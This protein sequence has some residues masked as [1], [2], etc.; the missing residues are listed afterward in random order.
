[1][2]YLDMCFL[3]LK[4]VYPFKLLSQNRVIL[5]S[6]KTLY[7]EMTE[8]EDFHI[9]ALN[10]LLLQWAKSGPHRVVV[11]SQT[12]TLKQKYTP[13]THGYG[14]QQK[15]RCQIG[16]VFQYYTSYTSQKTEI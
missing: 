2:T 4:A 11:G 10:N 6:I 1:M 5:S 9:T 16:N 3:T 15:R 13:H 14:Q 7:Q 12:S 8:R